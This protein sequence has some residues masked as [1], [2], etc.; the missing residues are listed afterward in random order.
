MKKQKKKS[1]AA[2]LALL[3]GGIGVH[4][5]YLGSHVKG[6]F[7]LLFCWTLIPGFIALLDAITYIRISEDDFNRI[8]VK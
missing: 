2:I 5:F 6:V 4:H 7:M 8:Y 1:T 3:L